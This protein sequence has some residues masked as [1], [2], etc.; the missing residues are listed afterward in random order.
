MRPNPLMP[1]RIATEFLLYLYL[2]YSSECPLTM[3]E[4]EIPR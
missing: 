2:F 4:R 1:T 3:R